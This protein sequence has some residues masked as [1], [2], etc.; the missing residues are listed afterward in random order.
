[1]RHFLHLALAPSTLPGGVQ[2]RTAVARLI[3]F[4]GAAQRFTSTDQGACARAVQVATI[5]VTTNAHLIGTAPATVEPIGF[6][7]RLHAPS[8]YRI[9][10]SRAS[11]A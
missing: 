2:T 11:M 9:G 6:L 4:C 8:K 5:A 10:Q 1:M 7:V 3:A